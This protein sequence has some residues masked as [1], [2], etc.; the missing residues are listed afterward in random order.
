M[1]REPARWRR[2]AGCHLRRSRSL[3]AELVAAALISVSAPGERAGGA[4]GAEWNP[5]GAEPAPA[6]TLVARIPRRPLHVRA[7]PHGDARII[8]DLAGYTPYTASPQRLLVTGRRADERG[9]RW[10]RVQLD[11]R[12]NGRSG[13]VPRARVHLQTT[14][15]RVVVFRRSR[16]MEV[17]REGRRIARWPV[18]IGRPDTPTPLG[19]FA[20]QDPVA[21]YGGW[22][23]IY[24]SHV[25][26]LTAHS[27]VIYSFLGGD[28][29]VAIHGT[30]GRPQRIGRGSSNGCVVLGDPELLRLAA[31]VRPGDPVDVVDA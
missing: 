16:T 11:S 21:T 28:G 26:A 24:G 6:R 2:Y 29:R 31:M 9:R 18:G 4:L 15:R 5:V 17:W 22:T 14:P 27:E 13:W 1:G 23:A 19:R 7:A 25:L 8:E 10:I 30:A 3:L 12:P 20:I